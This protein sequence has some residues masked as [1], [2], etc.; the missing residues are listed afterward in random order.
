MCI[1]G[2]LFIFRSGGAKLFLV[3]SLLTELL[4]YP[5]FGVGGEQD[6]EFWLLVPQGLEKPK[7]GGGSHSKEK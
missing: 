2:G 4:S 5:L 1:W 3:S 6:A 7:S